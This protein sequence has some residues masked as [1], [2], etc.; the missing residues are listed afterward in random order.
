MTLHASP[1][2]TLTTDFGTRDGYV[3][4]MKGVALSIC[5]SARLIDITH[6]VPPQDIAHGAWALR[7]A[8]PY[9]PP[10]TVHVA[11]IDPG[12]GTDRLPMIARIGD[13]WVIGPDNGLFDLFADAID[14]PIEARAITNPAVMRDTLSATFHGRDIFVAAAAHLAAQTPFET[15]GP[16]ID[17]PVRLPAARIERDGDTLR[18]A[19][20]VADHFGN[21]VTP[22]TRAHLGDA[23]TLSVCFDDRPDLSPVPGLSATYGHHPSPD[24]VALYGSEGYLE[25]AVPH[26]SARAALGVE[27]G[28]RVTVTLT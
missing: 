26:G 13:H 10:G 3:G 14:A 17:A 23:R 1:V 12:V 8:C 28:A 20:V 24:P 22:L 6:D 11:V 21:L 7:R 18:T 25:V 4:A 5:P 19:V 9:F 2:L 27:P 16:S 15:F